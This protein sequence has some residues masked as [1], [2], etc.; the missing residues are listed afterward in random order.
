M[1]LCNSLET[2]GLSFITPR[3]RKNNPKRTDRDF[4]T[5]FLCGGIIVFGALPSLA[6]AGDWL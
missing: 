4:R 1:S 2:K 6:A 3:N 5:K